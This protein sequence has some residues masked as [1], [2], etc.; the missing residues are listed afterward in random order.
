MMNL[1]QRWRHRGWAVGLLVSMVTLVSCGGTDSDPLS[2]YQ[3]QAP[4]WQACAVER[5]SASDLKL[6]QQLG[7]RVSCADI[8]VPLDYAHPT[9]GEIKVAV[10]RVQ[11]SG[12]GVNNP[13]IVINPGGPGLDGWAWPL[14]MALYWS[15]DGTTEDP[16]VVQS[17]QQ[18]AQRY[19]LIGFSPRGTGWSTKLECLHPQDPLP[20]ADPTRQLDPANIAKTLFNSELIAQACRDN[21]LMPHINTDATARDMDLIRHLLHQDKLN[22]IGLSYGTWLGN[23]YASLFPERVGRMLLS[24]VTDFSIPLNHQALP[25]DQ[26]RQL[27]LDKVLIPYAT[28]HPDHFG[29]PATTSA[30]R[31]MI[32]ALPDPLHAAI[33]NTLI[34]HNL[35][36]SASMADSAVLSLR[37]AQ[38]LHSELQANPGIDQASLLARMAN[39]DFVPLTPDATLNAITRTAA[40]DLVNRYFKPEAQNLDMFWSV[41]CNDSGTGFTPQTW[42]DLGNLN[43]RL[44]PDFGGSV[45]DNA[46]LYWRQ[47]LIARPS[48]QRATQAGPILMLQS[49]LD[50]LTVLPGAM[51]SLELLP[52]ASM[53]LINGEITHAP[54][55]P[56]GT[57]CVDQPIAAYFLDGVVPPRTTSCPSR[58]LAADAGGAP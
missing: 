30:L 11:A 41:V 12:T 14:M 53:V 34:D 55:P 36:S 25:Q 58:P 56:Y 28:R 6:A 39:F 13:A 54:M 42:V 26:G 40:E 51:N 7:A 5:F 38:V 17:Y 19:D 37:A 3:N 29:L 52:K 1:T 18:L 33:V 20:V 46:C 50:P 43:A 44:Y 35:L 27:V 10:L 21:P 45:R 49:T 15:L 31:Q 16:A 23:W 4:D 48:Q 2:R 47:P 24:G 8:R 22:Y 57:S 9:Q 32:D